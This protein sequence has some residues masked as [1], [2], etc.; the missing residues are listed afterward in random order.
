MPAVPTALNVLAAQGVTD[1]PLVPPTAVALAHPL[2]RIP[3]GFGPRFYV[4]F[5]LGLFWLVPAWR[6]P[7]MIQAMF[8]WDLL[9]LPA[10]DRLEV[11]RIWRTRPALAVPSEISI[12]LKNFSKIPIRAHVVDEAPVQLRLEPPELNLLVGV[13]TA[14]REKY[15]ILPAE[16]GDVRLGR[17]F[18]RYQ[19]ALRMAERWSVAETAQ[20]VSVLPN[21]DEAKRHTL[22]LIRSRQVEMEKRR[23]R[24]HGLG[25]E[26]DTLREYREGD[27][28]RDIS[29]TATARRHQVIT[30]VFQIERS[31]AVWIVL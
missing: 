28:I 30:R 1:K 31:Q 6:F 12:E 8:V 16:R 4:A 21:L 25:R 22:Y 15:S 9:R 5:L 3:F 13:K 27:E 7:R 17:V 11:R 10:A 24:Q 23:K 14:A 19:S 20:T 18:V 26:F 2:G 29:W